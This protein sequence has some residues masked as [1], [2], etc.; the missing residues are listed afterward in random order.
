MEIDWSSPWVDHIAYILDHL[1]DLQLNAEEALTLLVIEHSNRHNIPVSHALIETRLK[2]TMEHAEDLLNA[3]ADKGYLSCVV[4]RGSVRFV[5]D[6]VLEGVS[7]EGTPIEK[8]L[9]E[10][11]E[12]A[13]GRGLSGQEMQR[14][15]DLGSQYDQDRVLIALDEACAYEHRDLNYVERVL[16]SWKN[17][18]LTTEDL[19]KGFRNERQ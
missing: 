3:L 6:G 9:I 10:E 4:D 11:F 12:A 5:T 15:I 17:K 18:G 13:F 7:R 14:I 1:Q 16:V 8:S 2:T 19:K